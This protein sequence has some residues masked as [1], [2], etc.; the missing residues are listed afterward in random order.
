MPPPLFTS[1]QIWKDDRYYLNTKTQQW[2]RKYYLVMAT[3]PD[4]SDALTAVFTSKPNGL[5]D[6]PA[7]STGTPRAGHYVGIQGGFLV[8]E[9]WVEFSSIK[10]VDSYL[11][12]Q[13]V[14]SGQTSLTVQTLPPALFCSVLRC[15]LQ[16]ELDISNRGIR[17]LRDTIAALNCP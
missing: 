8:L 11:I 17:W 7:C 14:G 15:A 12:N 2:E 13:Q 10:I 9:S 1:G 16:V 3:S 5:T 4:G 6:D